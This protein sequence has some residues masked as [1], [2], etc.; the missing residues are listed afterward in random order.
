MNTNSSMTA[1]LSSLRRLRPSLVQTG[2]R[3]S[4]SSIKWR[5]AKLT[6]NISPF[7]VPELKIEDGMSTRLHDSFVGRMLASDDPRT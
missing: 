7:Q 2:P 4:F 1:R 6:G 3:N 5:S